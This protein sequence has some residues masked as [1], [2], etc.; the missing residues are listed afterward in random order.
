MNPILRSITLPLIAATTAA[1]AAA[2]AATP[3]RADDAAAKQKYDSGK[4]LYARHG[5]IVNGQDVNEQAIATLAD[6]ETQAQNPDLKYDIL[7][8]E[9]QAYFWKGKHTTGNNE[10]MTVFNTGMQKADAARQIN[11]DYAD[12]YYYYGINL[13]DWA[14]AKGVLASLTRK[15]EL[16][17]SAQGALDRD[18]KDGTPGE[19]LDG[20]GPDR[21]LGRIYFKLPGFA[22][23]SHA[24]SLQYLEKAFASA[25]NYACNVDY[26][27]ETLADGTGAEKDRAKQILHDLL[28]NDPSTYNPARVNDTT[29]EFG[30]ARQLLKELGG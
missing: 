2:S 3:A 25:K 16:I 13:G 27:A 23:G 28:A 19:A 12:A 29:E 10:Q 26:L 17:S 1:L 30:D 14:I 7:T 8:L 24:T 20:Y 15:N 21:T 4:A 9:S 18:A 11:P 5:D 6:A 22:G